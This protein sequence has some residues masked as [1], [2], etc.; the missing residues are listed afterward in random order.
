MK[1]RSVIIKQL[2]GV[3]YNGRNEDVLNNLLTHLYQMFTEY[4]S[5][6]HNLRDSYSAISKAMEY[7][8]RAIVTD[9]V[10]LSS[11]PPGYFYLT[12]G[13]AV[14]NQLKSESRYSQ[15]IKHVFEEVNND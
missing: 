2:L 7:S 11:N 10:K 13:N 8:W 1:G 5:G 6:Y 15:K 3:Y 4:V 14:K 9:K 12:I